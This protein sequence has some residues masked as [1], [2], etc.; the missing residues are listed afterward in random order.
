MFKRVSNLAVYANRQNRS[1][2]PLKLRLVV[3]GP[4][5]SARIK[6]FLIQIVLNYRCYSLMG[7]FPLHCLSG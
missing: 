5:A 1:L 7:V 2:Q 4:G 3:V 6:D